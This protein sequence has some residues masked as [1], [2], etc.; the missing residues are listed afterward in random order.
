LTIFPGSNIHTGFLSPLI[1]FFLHGDIKRKNE[2]Q[3][4]EKK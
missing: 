3:E 4:V 2:G 1:F